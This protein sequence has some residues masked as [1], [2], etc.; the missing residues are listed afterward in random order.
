MPIIDRSFDDIAIDYMVNSLKLFEAEQEII[1][2]NVFF[3]IER[4]IFTPIT[5]DECP[6]I[7]ITSGS[8]TPIDPGSRKGTSYRAV[9]NIDCYTRGYDSE[10][11]ERTAMSRLH[12]LKEQALY[13]LY[14]LINA[15]FGFAA[16]VIGSKD[17]PRWEFYQPEA[18]EIETTIT[19]GRWIIEI[20]YNWQPKDIPDIPLT[21]ISVNI[22]KDTATMWGAVYHYTED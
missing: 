22:K 4:D 10:I 8:I 1:D 14:Q 20:T 19:A 13:G 2:S 7:N 9:F 11:D 18:N 12:Y 15:D 5:D 17:W 21:Q 16:G 3:K 6:L